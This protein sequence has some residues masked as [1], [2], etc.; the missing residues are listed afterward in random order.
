MEQLCREAVAGR[1][2]K[3]LGI[4]SW[5]NPVSPP[6]ERPFNTPRYGIML[7]DGSRFRV[8]PLKNALVSFD[9]VAAAKCFA[10]VA[11]FLENDFTSGRVAGYIPLGSIEH[12]MNRLDFTGN[13]YGS[14][15]EFAG[16]IRGNSGYLF[17]L[18]KFS[19]RLLI[20]GEPDAP[21]W[22]AEGVTAFQ[23]ALKR[24][25]RGTP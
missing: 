14:P 25:T 13:G 2:L 23:E 3:K 15:E 22:G 9:S 17:R 5:R 6:E 21:V 4:P 11:V 12:G 18:L 20:L 7:A 19:L 16:M 8:C 10:V 24:K 1:W